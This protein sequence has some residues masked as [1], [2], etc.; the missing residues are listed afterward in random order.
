MVSFAQTAFVTR[1]QLALIAT[2]VTFALL[3]GIGPRPASADG[4]AS[5]RNIILG[6]AAVAAAVIITNNVRHKQ[7]AHNS[8]V[9]HTRDGG[10]VYAD[11]R[12][13]Y[14]NGDVLYT[15]NGGAQ[16]CSW[17]GSGYQRCGATPVAFYPQGQSYAH[18]HGDGHHYGWKNRHH[19]HGGHSHGHDRDD[20]HGD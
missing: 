14:P 1:I 6:T 7:L 17:S 4:A 11:G 2:A 18:R 13:V 9:G 20:E 12:V 19:E 5:T 15:S 10:I 8:I 16:R 3:A